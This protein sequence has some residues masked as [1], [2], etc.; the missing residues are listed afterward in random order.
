MEKKHFA[1]SRKI[2]V[3][4]VGELSKRCNIHT[5][6]NSVKVISPKLTDDI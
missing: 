1:E 3:S 4:I 2:Q 6:Y 5:L